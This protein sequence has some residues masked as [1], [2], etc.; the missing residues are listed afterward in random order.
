[1]RRNERKKET[2]R[3]MD[4]GRNRVLIKGRNGRMQFLR[5]GSIT[6]QHMGE[7]IAQFFSPFAASTECS[8]ALVDL[9]DGFS[10]KS[11]GVARTC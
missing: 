1:M 7:R 8:Y 6:E 11:H 9:K 4:E 2:S 3:T 5:E 10:G